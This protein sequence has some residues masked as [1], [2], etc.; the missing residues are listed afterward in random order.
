MGWYPK[1]V[2]ISPTVSLSEAELAVL[3]SVTAGTVAAGKAVVPTADKHIDTIVIS[4]DGLCIG[5]GAGTAMTCTAAELNTLD[6]V[7][8]TLTASELNI[9]DGVTATAAE[10]STLASSGITNSDLVKLHAV[11]ATAASLNNCVSFFD[12]TVTAAE[13]KACNHVVVPGIALKQFFPTFAA[14]V[15][16]GDVTT[17]TVITLQESTSSGVV[18]SHVAADMASGVWAGP[19]GGT[20]VTTKLNTALVVGEGIIIADTAPNSLTVCTAI[21][22]IVAGYYV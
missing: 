5:T 12:H 18:L 21:R 16:T 7:A 3:D 17:S 19:T 11:T 2:D 8:A 22:V 10:I 14:M 20:V 15:A 6:G 4:K 13:V 1:K 9:L